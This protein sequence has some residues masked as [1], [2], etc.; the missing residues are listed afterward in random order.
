MNEILYFGNKT[1]EDI[2]RNLK[3]IEAIWNGTIQFSNE[4]SMLPYSYTL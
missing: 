1:I 3:I 4:V 2:E